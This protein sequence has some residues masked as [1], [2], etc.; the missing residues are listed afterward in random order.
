MNLNI[1]NLGKCEY[2]EA[3]EIQYKLSELR[4]EGKVDDTLILVEHPPV[5][6]VGKNSDGNNV[7]LPDEFFEKRGIKVCRISRGGDVTY[8]GPG[9]IVGYPIVDL[10]SKIYKQSVKG[11]VAA[12]EEVFIRLLKENYG[13]EA[14]RDDK[15]TGVWVDNG[16]VVAIG[17]AISRWITMH[18]FAFNVNTNLEHF[19]WIVPCGIVG[20][21]V[22]SMSKLTG[23]DLNFDEVAGQVCKIFAEI[24]GYEKVTEVSVDFI[25]KARS[26]NE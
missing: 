25:D 19:K 5:I 1:L 10:K 24:T 7:V 18:G 23:G 14:G 8:H 15:Y 20:K 2:E 13:I 17:V 6:T 26:G 9:Q 22:T 16:K 3:L 21:E 12:L 4:A 11:Y